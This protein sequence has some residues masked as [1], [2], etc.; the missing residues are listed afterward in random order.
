MN[1]E[2]FPQTIKPK[3]DFVTCSN[4]YQK[5]IFNKYQKKCLII[6]VVNL[7]EGRDQ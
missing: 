7:F 1:T 3:T 5:I 4:K 6:I 2:Y